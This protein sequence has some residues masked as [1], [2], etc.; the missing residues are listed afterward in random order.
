MENTRRMFLKQIAGVSLLFFYPIKQNITMNTQGIII[1]TSPFEVKKT[2]DRLVTLLEKNGATVYSRINQQSEVRRSGR[3][4]P[5]MEFILF[6]NP[7]N[8][9]AIMAAN[10]MAAL[11]LPL[12]IL[13]WE[14][15]DE[16]VR[17]AFNDEQYIQNRYS[18]PSKLTDTLD[19][20]PLINK[21]L[22]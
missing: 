22:A 13:A 7:T 20:N 4:M 15:D 11:D 19:L 14:G 17:V 18:L 2:I 3:E 9:G 21:A 1:R 16:I 6:G 12:K 10:P 5:P 8:G